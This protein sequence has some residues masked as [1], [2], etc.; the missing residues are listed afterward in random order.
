MFFFAL[1]APPVC[2][3]VDVL[4]TLCEAEMI[5]QQGCDVLVGSIEITQFDL[6]SAY[7]TLPQLASLRC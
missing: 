5:A 6:L 3:D 7:N 4:N 1:C 2:K